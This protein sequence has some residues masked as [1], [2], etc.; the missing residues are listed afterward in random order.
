MKAASA[1]LKPNSWAS[2]AAESFADVFGDLAGSA[3]EST[4]ESLRR[5]GNFHLE[6]ALAEALAKALEFAG[7]E[8]PLSQLHT[9]WALT[10]WRKRLLDTSAGAREK[11]FVATDP[12]DPTQLT[13]ELTPEAWWDLMVPALSRWLN[14]DAIPAEVTVFLQPHLYGYLRKAYLHTLRDPQHGKAWIGYQQRY[15]ETIAAG[16]RADHGDLAD[17][18]EAL[19]RD[20]AEMKSAVVA[21]LE[22]QTERVLTA[23]AGMGAQVAGVSSQVAEVGARITD[24]N[25]QVAGV[26]GQVTALDDKLEKALN[27]LPDPAR[28]HDVPAPTAHFTGRAHHLEQIHQQLQNSD[29]PAVVAA[30]HGLGGV[31]KTQI[32]LEYAR[33]HSSAYG[34]LWFINAANG[35]Y[36]DFAAL[37]Q[38]ARL[39]EADK[40]NQEMVDAVRRFLRDARQSC[41]DG[42]PWLLI[43]DNAESVESL[44]PFLVRGEAHGRVLITSRNADWSRITRAPLIEVDKWPRAESVDF[45]LE[46]TGEAERVAADAVAA[47]L[48]DL[49]LAL[50]QAAAFVRA[51]PSSLAAYARLL[52]TSKDELMLLYPPTPDYPHPVATTWHFAFTRLRTESPAALAAL[53]RAA[54]FAPESIPFSLLPEPFAPSGDELARG[55][56]VAALVTRYSLAKLGKNEHAGATLTVHRLVQAVV[57]KM[58]RVADRD[59]A[60]LEEALNAANV[61]FGFKTN[62]LETW[63]P[64][65]AMDPHVR[66]VSDTAEKVEVG[67]SVCSQLL[68]RLGLYLDV[69]ARYQDE[70]E[71]GKRSL[72]LAERVHGPEHQEVAVRCNNLGDTLRSLGDLGAARVYTE[73]ALRLDEAVYGPDHPTVAMRANNLGQI[74]QALGDL[75][76][77]REYTE[78]AL[79][80]DKAVY[81]PDHPTVAIRTNNLGT[82]HRDLGDIPAARTY[83]ERA[84]RICTATLGPDHPNTRTAAD[85]LAAL[86]TT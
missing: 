17:R 27:R 48:E 65:G 14:G 69:L 16:V 63:K 80:I 4:L 46:R 73:R 74:H 67:L 47:E 9:R 70:L 64:A 79:R 82:I 12:V 6:S 56:A 29:S 43:Y 7:E 85:N 72:A 1:C 36:T 30:L 42:R 26:G 62:Q 52:A 58:L 21:E 11:L 35:I 86:D 28:L 44:E 20:T 41:A 37:A 61:G 34:L 13:A 54:W 3:A 5:D 8:W 57:R 25:S 53:E 71:I 18:I 24:V 39:P 49:P 66:A 59:K 23:I 83:L 76:A 10:A 60:V 19:A 40:P 75:G 2:F 50:E 32:A 33:R 55:A 78:R 15:L 51:R 77:A 84:L 38:A 22:R 68:N 81:G 31:G 45:L